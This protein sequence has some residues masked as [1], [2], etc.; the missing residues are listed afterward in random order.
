MKK[1]DRGDLPKN[2][3][4][5]RLAFRRIEEIHAVIKLHP[6]LYASDSLLGRGSEIGKSV[7]I[8]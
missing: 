7:F 5:D 1:F 2:D 4:L 6:D 8:Y 3:W